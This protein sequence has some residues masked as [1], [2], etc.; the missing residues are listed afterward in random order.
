[1]T[2]SDDDE[3]REYTVGYK[4]PPAAHRFQKGQSGNPSGGKRKTRGKRQAKNL[5]AELLDELGQQ[6]PVTE[7]G[8]RRHMSRRTVLVKKLITDALNGDPKSRDQLF[9]LANQAEANPDTA[10]A[11]DLIGAAKDAEILERFRAEIIAK[12]KETSDD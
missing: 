7:N 6:V 3:D 2:K 5:K 4:K 9:K 1:M 10:D 8:R 11:D 12:Y